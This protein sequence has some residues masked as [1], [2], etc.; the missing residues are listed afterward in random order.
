MIWL[1]EYTLEEVKNNI[2]REMSTISRQEFQTVDK[3][4]RRC[5][6]FGQEG[7]NFSITGITGQFMLHF[8]KVI[9]TSFLFASFTDSYN[10]QESTM[11]SHSRSVGREPIFQAGKQNLLHVDNSFYLFLIVTFLHLG[12]QILILNVGDFEANFSAIDV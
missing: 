2:R 12:H 3:D 9:T 10:S 1:Q 7:N 4:F 8:L 6:S 11:T 5:T